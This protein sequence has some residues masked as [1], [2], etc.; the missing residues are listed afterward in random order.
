MLTFRILYMINV[1]YFYQVC[2]V[3]FYFVQNVYYIFNYWYFYVKL[4][5]FPV[6]RFPIHTSWIVAAF[7]QVTKETL[8]MVVG[9]NMYQRM[10]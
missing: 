6:F 10:C 4:K 7:Q 9:K 2:F 8:I 5:C 1:E 3:N